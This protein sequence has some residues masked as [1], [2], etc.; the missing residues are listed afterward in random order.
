MVGNL[1]CKVLSMC[2]LSCDDILS[3]QVKEEDLRIRLSR[4]VFRFE[5]IKLSFSLV[6]K[7]THKTNVAPTTSSPPCFIGEHSARTLVA[8]LILPA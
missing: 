7:H 8:W 4:S 3:K 6:C 2:A 1:I 5:S